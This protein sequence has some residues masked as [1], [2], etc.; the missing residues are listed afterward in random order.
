MSIVERV[1]K[2]QLYTFKIKAV[3]E[4][5]QNW[6]WALL[7]GSQMKPANLGA[8]MVAKRNRGEGLLEGETAALCSRLVKRLCSSLG[9]ASRIPGLL[10]RWYPTSLDASVAGGSGERKTLYLRPF[11]HEIN[12]V[13]GI[14]WI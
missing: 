12:R 14:I 1:S 10:L 2:E 4:E 8:E 9:V 11:L 7:I 3:G 13:I 6:R 5:I